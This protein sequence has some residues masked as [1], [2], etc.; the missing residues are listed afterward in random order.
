M[1]LCSALLVYPVAG[2]VRLLQRRPRDAFAP[3]PE[4]D[5]LGSTP[6]QTRPWL[7]RLAPWSGFF[8]ALILLLFTIILGVTAFNM[9][10]SNDMRILFG[11][12]GTSRPLFLLP[13]LALLFALVMLLGMAAAWARGTGSVWGRLY[14]TVITSAAL[15][16]LVILAVWGMLTAALG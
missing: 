6:V 13:P 8:T 16:C 10:M 4:V 12:P 15:A 9:A 1:V 11:L 5:S 14:L 7:S 2:L 3:T